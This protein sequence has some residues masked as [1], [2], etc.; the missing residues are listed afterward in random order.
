M[1][2]TGFDITPLNLGRAILQIRT[3][4]DI[5]GYAEVGRRSDAFQAYLDSTIKPLLI[6]QDPRKI[7]RH[8]ETLYLGDEERITK[9]PPHVVGAVDIALWGHP[10]QRRR[11]AL[12][13]THGRR[14]PP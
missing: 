4:A 2:I 8:W 13:R 12:P 5:T 6:G 9:L 7:D 11:Y 3:S 1:K 10:R 14:S